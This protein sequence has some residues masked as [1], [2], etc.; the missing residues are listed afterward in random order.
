MPDVRGVAFTSLVPFGNNFDRVTV[1]K[2]MGEPERAS[3]DAPEGDR[4]FVSPGYF[5]TTGVR[6]L[7]GRLFDAGD[8]FDAPVVCV[9]DSVFARH[10]FG[11]A[12]AI[13][14]QMKLPMRDEY[15]TIVGIVTHVKTY[16]LD[17]ESPGQIYISNVQYPFRW[18]SLLV[19]TT[20]DPAAFAPTVARVVHEL[21]RDQPATE[22]ATM[23]SLM[24]NLLR[25]RKFTLMLL[26]VFAAVALLLAVVGLYGVIAYGVS[27]RGREFGIRVALGAR[28]SQIGRMVVFEGIRI[29]LAGA[30]LGAIGAL[31]A[32]RLVSSMLFEV[33][34][35][36]AFVLS[37]VT[38]G[39]VSV[40]IVACLVPARRATRVDLGGVLR[41]D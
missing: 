35:R 38:V 41:G 40:A 26:G 14:K 4:Y 24:S 30:M 19:R 5:S 9:V 21:D 7:R 15:A 27:Q 1:T 25:A 34:A 6:L 16:G 23:D 11:S 12:D 2:I 29:A 10:A 22:S 33:S 18:M 20:G 3:S 32:G 31:A 8:R 13:G 39:M 37:A 28:G 17:L 36:D